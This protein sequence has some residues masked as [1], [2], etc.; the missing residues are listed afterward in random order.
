M[1]WRP[2]SG[3]SRFGTTAGVAVTRW[4][5]PKLD[6]AVCRAFGFIGGMSETIDEL[7]P[8][9]YIVVE[10]PGN[11]FNGDIAPALGDLVDRDLVRVLD[12]V[13][14]TKDADGTIEGFELGDIDEGIAGEI[15]KLEID[16]AHVLSEDDVVS[17]AGA[18]E[19]GS[20]AALLVW[21]NKWAAPFASAVRHSG[22]QLGRER[23]DPR[24]SADR[25]ARGRRR[26][27]LTCRLQPVVSHAA[28][29]SAR[30]SPAP[31][32]SSEPRPSWPTVSTAVPIVVRAGATDAARRTPRRKPPPSD[33]ART[34]RPRRLGARRSAVTG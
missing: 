13:F 25:R 11:K 9:D 32:P 21:E 4:M 28:E 16:I 34:R 24:T 19:P 30:P 7:G 33:S 14:V 2:G 12:L 17:L 5:V 8:V 20:S 23:P 22:G 3:L 27:S 26:R 18:L 31:R 6:S 1:A 15:E 10:F 29:S